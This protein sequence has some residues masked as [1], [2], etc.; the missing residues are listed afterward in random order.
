RPHEAIGQKTP[1]SIYKP[2]PRR[3]PDELPEPDYP[4]DFELRRVN[5]AGAVKWKCELVFLGAVLRGQ[6]VGLEPIDDGLH[7]L[8]FGPVFLGELREKKSGETVFTS[9]KN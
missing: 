9:N 4:D 3:M 2:C 8:W 6:G 1:D 5:H 7:R